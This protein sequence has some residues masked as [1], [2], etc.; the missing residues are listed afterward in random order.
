LCPQTFAT[1]PGVIY[2]LK[3]LAGSLSGAASFSIGVSSHFYHAGPFVTPLYAQGLT[4]VIGHVADAPP[5][6]HPEWGYRLEVPRP[7]PLRPGAGATVAF[8]LPTRASVALELFDLQGRR[9]ATRDA[10]DAPA[11]SSSVR[12]ALP[13]I[14]AGHYQ[15]RLRAD[16]NGKAAQTRPIPACRACKESFKRLIGARKKS[17]RILCDEVSFAPPAIIT[18]LNRRTARRFSSLATPG[19]RR[20]RTAFDGTTTPS[21]VPSGPTLASRTIF[22]TG[23]RRVTTLS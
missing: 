5:P 6:R 8:T 1:G 3:F 21:N 17:N 4:V 23:R 16:G 12:W 22:A 13:L 19:I 20:G 7:N 9:V 14:P 11:G 18:P 10:G 15:L 2:R